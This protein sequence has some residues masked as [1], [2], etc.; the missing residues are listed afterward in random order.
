MI[1]PPGTPDLE[2]LALLASVAELG[3]FGAA[4]R[5]HGISQP[6]ASM[7]IGALERRLNLRLVD[8]GRS[9]S[10]LTD[11]GQTVVELGEPVL[12]AAVA[13]TDGIAAL[14]HSARPSLSI[15]ASTTIADHRIPHWLTALR[16]IHPDLAVTLEVA[17]SRQV[18]AAVRDRAA[19][20][21]FA[22]GPHPPPGLGSRVLA[23]D[24]LVVVVAPTHRWATRRRALTPRELADTPLL[25]REKGSGTRDTVWETLEIH[26]TPAPPAAELGS[27]AAILA[28]ARSGAAP[29]VV[30]RLIVAHELRAGTLHEVALTGSTPL[31]RKFRAIWHRG[32]PPDGP[33]AD[34]L[35]LAT[36]IEAARTRPK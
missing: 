33:A 36:R 28:T 6:A 22:E 11:A 18:I 21:G 7:R 16:K 17:N 3:S 14:R 15:V 32:T 35:E 30:S 2:A 29:A 23:A 12:A 5:R 20:L 9:G 24:E 26:G 10:V 31:T 4:A 13:L 34:L 27:A 1:L 8:R 19:G 25:W